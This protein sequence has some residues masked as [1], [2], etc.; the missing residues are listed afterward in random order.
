MIGTPASFASARRSYAEDLN[1]I[2]APANTVMGLTVER[3]RQ[4]TESGSA[5][6]VVGR[7]NGG[8][9]LFPNRQRMAELGQRNI[10]PQAW[11]RRANISRVK[12]TLITEPL[13]FRHNPELGPD[14]P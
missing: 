4:T 7:S 13:S 10:F 12:L 3:A 14:L 6:T 9:D 11:P 5:D 2:L 1:T 8:P